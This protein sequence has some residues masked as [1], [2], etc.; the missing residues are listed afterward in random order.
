MLRLGWWVHRNL[1]RLSGGR[2]GRRVSGFEVLLLTTVGRK[3]G[4]PR[5]AALQMLPHG[6]G[7]AVIASHAGED[8]HPA[9]WLNLQAQPEAG[10]QV[11]SRRMRV[12]AREATG[13]E[14][15]ELWARFVAVDDAYDE[16]V[17]RTTRRIPV[18]VLEPIQAGHD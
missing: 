3:S 10:A 1:Y 6:E 5:Q 11:R 18:V 7:W 12:R 4:E 17:R 9:W 13:T 8:R 14:R 16:Y 2:I 15:D